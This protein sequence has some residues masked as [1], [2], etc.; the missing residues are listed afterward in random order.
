MPCQFKRTTGFEM[1]S[2]IFLL[3][4]AA[5]ITSF[6]TTDASAAG[7]VIATG[8]QRQRIQSTPIINRPDRPFHVYGNTVRRVYRVRRAFGF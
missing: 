3:L 7:P 4:A 2:R 8:A 5:F 6:A 1:N